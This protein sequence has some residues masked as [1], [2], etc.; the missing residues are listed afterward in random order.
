M[1]GEEGG[2]RYLKPLFFR[3]SPICTGVGGWRCSQLFSNS[4]PHEKI[5]SIICLTFSSD[6]RFHC[7]TPREP[8]TQL[9]VPGRRVIP[10]KFTALLVVCAQHTAGSPGSSKPSRPRWVPHQPRPFR[11]QPLI[12]ES[13]HEQADDGHDRGNSV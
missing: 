2:K 12:E 9:R 4:V 10:V 7:Q 6:V 5:D 11:P 13:R 1:T 8:A 3:V